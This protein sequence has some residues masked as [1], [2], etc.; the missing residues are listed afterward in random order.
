MTVTLQTRKPTG[1]PSWPIVLLAGGEKTGKTFNAAK[2]TGSSLIGRT[3]WVTIG[4]DQPDE[5][6]Q[7]GDFDIVEHDGSYRAILSALRAAA[8]Q[9]APARGVPLLVVDSM[10]RLWDLLKENAQNV[11]NERKGGGPHKDAQVTA[12]LWNAAAAQWAH[13]MDAIRSFPGP[14]VLTARLDQVAVMDERGQPTKERIAKVQA[15]KSLPFDVGALVE[16]PTLGEVWVSGVRSLR[17]QIT[18]RTAVPEDFSL[19]WFWRKLGLADGESTPREH[20]SPEAE[21]EPFDADGIAAGL[22]QY[23]DLEQ[24]SA[25]WQRLTPQQRATPVDG[26]P[27]GDLLRRRKA[28]LHDRALEPAFALNTGAVEDEDEMPF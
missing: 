16:M 3:Y 28:L 20:V 24:L 1:K 2:A 11:A 10:T 25:L 13:V 17:L 4:E 27:L 22:D 14:V 26:R 23:D 19:D 12:D 8:A 9:P 21:R 6:G 7:L 5:Y 18:E 15:H